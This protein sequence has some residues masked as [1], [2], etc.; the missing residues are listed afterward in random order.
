MKRKDNII[1][2]RPV[3]PLDDDG[4]NQN[5]NRNNRERTIAILVV[6]AMTI[7][8][9]IGIVAYTQWTMF[10]NISVVETYEDVNVVNSSCEDFL[11]GFLKYG[12]DGASYIDY[13][14]ETI[15]N[16]PYEISNPIAATS[17]LSAVIADLGGNQIVV[18]DEDGIKGEFET[19]LPIE[20]I[21]VSEQGIVAVLMYDGQSPQIICYDAAGNTL[22]ELKSTLVGNGYPTSLS[23]SSDAETLLVSYLQI[24]ETGIVGNYIYYSF[25]NADQVTE[26]VIASGSKESTIIPEVKFLKSNISVIISE[27]SLEIF[28]SDDT[29][30]LVAE[31]E[32]ENDVES[33]FYGDAQ[34]GLVFKNSV[35]DTKELRVYNTNGDVIVS[36]EIT[37]EYEDIDIINNQ[38]ILYEKENCIIYTLSGKEKYNGEMSMELSGVF[39]VFGINKYVII[40]D[41]GMKEVRLTR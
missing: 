3:V 9:S 25:S 15:W 20:K 5:S 1:H 7:A 6:V 32:F 10:T 36:T 34:V 33:V 35:G 40:G 21:T 31:I 24:S 29:V 11:S 38:I 27:Q 18:V 2:L 39:P 19:Y 14:G 8:V 30:E 16:E 13:Q 28:K 26:D 41:E 17:S 22:V 23:L 12:K 37:G 4:K